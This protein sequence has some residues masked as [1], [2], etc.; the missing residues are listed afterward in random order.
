MKYS[1][2]YESI[3]E[4]AIGMVIFFLRIYARTRLVG[5][6]GWKGDDKIIFVSM[7]CWSVCAVTSKLINDSGKVNIVPG[8][9][10]P[11]ED[12]KLLML[13]LKLNW[14]GWFFYITFI[15]SLKGAMLFLYAR[16][17]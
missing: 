5:V 15:W 11:P 1:W 2:F 16:L 7:A 12:M 6:K 4:Y 14:V 8:K 13:S 10:T 3:A 9:P 17:T